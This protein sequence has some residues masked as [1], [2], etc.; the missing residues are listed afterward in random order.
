MLLD[1][2]IKR[3]LCRESIIYYLL[4]IMHCFDGKCGI[5]HFCLCHVVE[6]CWVY[7]SSKFRVIYGFDRTNLDYCALQ[8]SDISDKMCPV[9]C[10][11][12]AIGDLSSL[13][14]FTSDVCQLILW[15]N[16]KFSFTYILFFN[17]YATLLNDNFPQCTVDST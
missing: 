17:F 5:H 10:M 1:I 16:L 2:Q 3:M 4:Y 13:L 12:S 15:F 11:C 7:D 8:Q 9:V 6:W 14:V